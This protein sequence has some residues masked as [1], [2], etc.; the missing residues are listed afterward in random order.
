MAEKKS[1]AIKKS[2]RN[3]VICCKFLGFSQEIISEKYIVIVNCLLLSVY[4]L[5]D[6]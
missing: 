1:E 6:A 3:L 4:G 2:K 5:K